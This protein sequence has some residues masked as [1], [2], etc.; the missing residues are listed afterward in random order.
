MRV[1]EQPLVKAR[2]ETV[3]VAFTDLVGSTELAS[4]L[5]HDAY[6]RLRRSHFEGLRSAVANH[7]GSEIKTT[8]DG[9]MLRFTSTADAVACAIAMQQ[10]V[11]TSHLDSAAPLEIRIGVSSGEATL[12]GDDLYGPPVVEAS[13]LC[14]AASA[15]QILVSDV[16]RSLTR[17]RGHRFTS[18]GG[19]T[20]KGLPE[21]VLAFEVVWEPLPKPA[22]T[23]TGIFARTGEYWTLGYG[24][25][26]CSLKDVKGLSYIQRLLQHPGEEFQ[27]LDLLSGPGS[28]QFANREDQNPPIIEGTHS[29]GGLGDAGELLDAQAKIAYKRKAAELTEELEDLRERGEHERAEKVEAEIEFLKRELVR[30]VGLG[31]RDRRAGSAAERARLNATRAIKSAIDKIA[32]HSSSLGDLLE[33]AIRTGYYCSYIAVAPNSLTWRF[34]LD[35]PE[36]LLSTESTAPVLLRNEPSFTRALIGRT[37]FAGREAESSSLYRILQLARRGKGRV[38]MIGGAPGV[39]KSR[40]AAELCAK[41]SQSGVLVFAGNCY[42]RDDSVPF[43]S[44]VEILEAILTSAPS[45][46]AFRD[47]LGNESAEIARLMPQLRRMFPDIP[48]P[49]QAS[50]EQSRRILFAAINDLIVRV[51]QQMPVVLL[52]ED[53]Q[54]ADEGTLSLLSHLARSLSNAAVLVLGT[55]RDHELDPAGPL[56]KTLDELLRLHLLE[57][58][59]LSALPHD[60][61]AA[62]LRDLSGQEPPSVVVDFICSATEGNPFFVEEMFQHLV[63]RGKL[64]DSD[65]AFRADFKPS[66]IEVPNSLRPLIA[67]RLKSLGN[68][69]QR[70]LGVAAVIGRS[71]TFELLHAASKIEEDS[72]LEGIEEAERAG[73]ISASME[74]PE[75]R[76]QF[77]HELIRQAVIAGLSMPRRQ[78][79]HLNV[80]DAIE[81][82][83]AAPE[84]YAGD[85]AHHLWQA[86]SV[87]DRARTVRY[88]AMAARQAMTRSAGQETITYLS[89][90]LELLRTLPETAERNEQ[91]LELQVR[92]GTALTFAKGYSAPDVRRTYARARE[93]CQQVGESAQLFRTLRGLAG[94]YSVRAEHTTAFELSEQCLS[95]AQRLNDPLLLVGAHMELGATLF[96]LGDYNTAR[97]HLDKAIALHDPESQRLHAFV[98]GQDFGA[99]SRARASHVLWLSVQGRP[100]RPPR[101]VPP[102]LAGTHAAK[103][104]GKKGTVIVAFVPW[105]YD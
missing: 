4:R 36:P 42:D 63:E 92:L 1:P 98:H 105:L 22:S 72:A 25:K 23:I 52:L 32:E 12:D 14:A 70:I 55:Y 86:R 60:A 68:S 100:A 9:L 6:E 69:A 21:P 18:V 99:S 103:S 89:R 27:A 19:L 10:S 24:G 17:G 91:E 80:A 29:I 96:C 74:Y 67:R 76:F 40:I 41:A 81:R 73:L 71:F 97:T 46:K 102:S 48:L 84:A 49:L 11:D 85:L 8:G 26:T 2:T 75:A 5:G 58:I 65:G 45:P 37:A 30:A 31:G 16:V 33:R 44:F 53:L 94:Y 64:L 95:L 57:R 78:R 47:T 54:W 43:V 104:L 87:A 38:A 59:S 20:L 34:S 56:A 13:R 88:L 82:L 61:V 39:G 15:Q 66:A 35:T 101:A 7:N 79:H 93:L 77:S 62:M 90:G 50:P 51:S 28:V 3:T 83:Y